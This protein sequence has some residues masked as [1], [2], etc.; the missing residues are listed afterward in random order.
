MKYNIRKY[1]INFS[2]KLAKNT[3]TKIVNLET[4]LKHVEK[5]HENY[6]DNIDY[7]VWKQQVDAIYE[8]KA[9]GKKVRSKCNWYE[10]L[11]KSTKFFLNFEKHRAI[12]S[13]K[14][15][16]ITNQDEITDQ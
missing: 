7:H 4:N 5:Y 9:K 15:F 16:F 1:A 6:V 11:K 2:K 14:H 8:E 3:N 13:Q 12:Q 10:L